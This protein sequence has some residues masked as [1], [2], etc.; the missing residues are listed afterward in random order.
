MI[1]S[2]FQKVV[3]KLHEH[4]LQRYL[5]QHPE[6]ASLRALEL[7]ELLRTEKLGIEYIEYGKPVFHHEFLVEHGN[8]AR[9]HS[10]YTAAGMLQDRQ[11]SGISGHTHRLGSH[12]KTDGNGR[13]KVWFENGCLC[14][15]EPEYIYGVPNFQHGFSIGW[16]TADDNRFTVEQVPIIK[17]RLF[18]KGRIWQ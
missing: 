4:R 17:G 6:I 9:K 5:W 10:A 14:D 8:I 11:I 12:Y 3:T 18:Y 1:S 13:V 2:L 15:L 7:P 16:F